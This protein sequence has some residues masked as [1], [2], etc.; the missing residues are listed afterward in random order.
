M[1]RVKLKMK[2]IKLNLKLMMLLLIS[3]F[4]WGC[5]SGTGGGGGN[6]LEGINLTAGKLGASGGFVDIDGDGITDKIIGAPSATKSSDLGIALVYKGDSIGYASTYTTMAGDN[7]FGSSF[8]NLGDVDG[9]LKRILPLALSMEME[10]MSPCL[11]LFISIKAAVM[12]RL[13]SRS[14]QVRFLWTGLESQWLQ[15]I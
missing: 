15:E 8:V 9:I 2:K 11:A 7:S 13:S 5:S 12:V 3:S 14:L 4:L 1:T 6:P 10:R